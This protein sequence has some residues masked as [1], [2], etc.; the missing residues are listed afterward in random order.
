M[1]QN[2]VGGVI[3]F[4]FFFFLGCAREEL[5][6]WVQKLGGGNL[7]P[8]FFFGGKSQYKF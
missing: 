2:Q 8:F 1:A 3:E 6:S 5:A 7:A 4:F